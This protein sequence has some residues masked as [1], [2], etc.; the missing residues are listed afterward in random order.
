MN[1]Y[2]TVTMPRLVLE[3]VVAEPIQAVEPLLKMYPVATAASVM[4]SRAHAN[5]EK[6]YRARASL[7]RVCTAKRPRKANSSTSSTP[8]KPWSPA[9][10]ASAM[11]TGQ[12]IA[13]EVRTT[14]RAASATEIRTRH[15]GYRR[16]PGDLASLATCSIGECRMSLWS[17]LV[18]PPVAEPHVMA[19]TCRSVA[20]SRRGPPGSGEPQNR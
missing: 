17:A 4:A 5:V 10:A 7:S 9:F 6:R 11:R 18:S 19:M 1:R 13:E 20:A 12:V 3:E 2:S 16:S 8:M 14:T 15:V